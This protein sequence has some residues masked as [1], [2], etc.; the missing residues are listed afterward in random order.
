MREKG[1]LIRLR[2]YGSEMRCERYADMNERRALWGL[3]TETS[4]VWK[5]LAL[6]IAAKKLNSKQNWFNSF[7]DNH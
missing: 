2:L 6:E 5:A 3:L 4:H 1:D 7:N